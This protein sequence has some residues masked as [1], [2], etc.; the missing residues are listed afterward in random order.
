MHCEDGSFYKEQWEDNLRGAGWAEALWQYWDY[1][2]S[3][4]LEVEVY[5]SNLFMTP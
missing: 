4:L 1:V 2:A 3:K 5:A